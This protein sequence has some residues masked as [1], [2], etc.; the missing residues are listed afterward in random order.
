[1]ME[2]LTK[3]L[4]VCTLNL[5]YYDIDVFVEFSSDG[6]DPLSNWNIILRTCESLWQ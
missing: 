2:A 4:Q 1:M 6:M 3:M 5:V